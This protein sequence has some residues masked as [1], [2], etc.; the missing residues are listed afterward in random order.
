MAKKKSSKTSKKKTA[1]KPERWMSEAFQPETKGALHRELGVP[2]DEPIPASKLAIKPSDSPRTKKR[3]TL[4]KTASKISK[5]K[6]TK[7]KKSR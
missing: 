3:K 6:A 7:K 4:A 2:E 1:K 5:K